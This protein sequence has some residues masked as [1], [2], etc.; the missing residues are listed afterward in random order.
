MRK[1]IQSRLPQN[2]IVL[3]SMALVLVTGACSVFSPAPYGG[4]VTIR[5]AEVLVWNDAMP[6]MKPRCNV[7]SRL[8]LTNK[9]RETLRLFDIDA[10]I[11]DAQSGLSLRRF[12]PSFL[13]N[14]LPSRDI[15]IA[16]GDSVSVNLRSPSWGIEPIDRHAHPD[17]LLTFRALTSAGKPVV[18]TS[19][20]T[21]MFETQ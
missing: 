9:T 18:Y 21:T 1:V 6:G 14:E 2:N 5:E 19:S 12:P 11:V 13:V 20:V 17:V 4:L 16:A 15:S 10:Q 7:T 3:L 8:V